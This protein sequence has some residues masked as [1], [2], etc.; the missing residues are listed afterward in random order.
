MAEAQSN[1][2]VGDEERPLR[3]AIIGSGPAGFY[4]ADALFKADRAI[5]VDLFDRLPTPYGL[6]RGGVA[7]DHQSIKAV[8][9]VY[10]KTAGQPAFRFFGN[11]ELGRDLGVE[12]LR[13]HYDQIVY[14]VGNEADRRLGIPGEGIQR[15]TPGAVFVGWYNGHPDY[16]TASFDLSRPRVAIVGNG[17]VAIDIA[18]ILAKD[19]DELAKT[20]IANHALEALRDSAIE[21]IVVLGRRGPVQAAFTPAELK[22]LGELA[23]ATALVD[24][25]ELELD[26]ASAAEL[27]EASKQVRRNFEI[28]Q[29][30]AQNKPEEGKRR[31]RLRFCV[32]PREL[33][34]ADDGGVG[35][36]RIERN[37]LVASERGVQAVASGVRET[38]TIDTLLTA[39]GFSGRPLPGIAFDEQAGVIANVDG[40]VVDAK[41][42]NEY[43]VGWA[44]S[45]PRGLIGTHKKASAEV[46]Q[47]MLADADAAGMPKIATVAPR[48]ALLDL[49]DE[50]SVQVVSFGQWQVLD[51]LERERGE[52]RGAPRDKLTDVASMLEV[53]QK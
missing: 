15:C 12:D 48:A 33:L 27:A 7:P 31:L 21:E 13:A 34:P 6:V 45:G 46:V 29:E 28:L 8:T 20:D 44:K 52:R 1:S 30:L 53:L 23:S 4:A 37:R 24:P 11:V 3:V 10:E 47:S 2:H 43:V 16:R 36:L 19:A 40:R 5:E 22:E 50:R 18:R 38:L 9:K 25:E 49:L 51:Q 39:I 35:A 17:N 26:E 32:S 41:L 42:G 14:A